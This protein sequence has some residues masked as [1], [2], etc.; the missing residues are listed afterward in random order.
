MNRP[1]THVCV[2]AE[3]RCTCGNLVAIRSESG[4]EIL[5]RRCKRVHIIPWLEEVVAVKAPAH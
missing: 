1:A 2:R 5:C 4:V 3:E